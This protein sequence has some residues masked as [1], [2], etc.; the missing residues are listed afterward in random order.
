MATFLADFEMP[1][2]Q[3]RLKI[4]RNIKVFS[5]IHVSDAFAR[6]IICAAPFGSVCQPKIGPNIKAV[7]W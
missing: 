2:R 4:D 5:R 7:Y 1:E 3:Q 6:H